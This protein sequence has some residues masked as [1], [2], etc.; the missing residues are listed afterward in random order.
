MNKLFETSPSLAL[1]AQRLALGAVI[2]PHG[3]QKAFGWFHGYG[4]DGTMGFFASL[5]VPAPLAFLVIVSD[6]LGSAALIAGIATRA[7]AF[8]ASATM[9]G[10]ILLWHLPNGFFMNWGG[11]QAGEGF[12]FHILALGLSVP[13]TFLGG[14]AYSLDRLIARVLGGQSSASAA[15]PSPTAAE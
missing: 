1:L 4:F 2:L 12:E 14:G 15:L 6:L 7:A 13:L 3:L 8:G 5:G 10:A 9:L 11:T